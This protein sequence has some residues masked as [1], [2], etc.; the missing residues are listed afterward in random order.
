M[1]RKKLII[2]AI[3]LALVVAIGG[4]LAYFTDVQTKTNRF[5]MG[6][7]NILVDEPNWPGDPD[8]PNDEVPV[9]PNQ[10]TPK[11]PQITNQG[12]GEVYAFVKVT[13]PVASVKVGDATTATPTELFTFRHI[14]TP[15]QGTTPAVTA[16]GINSGWTLV[17]KTPTTL[18]ATTTSVTYVYAYGS[19]T[20]LTALQK[21]QTT[22]PIFDAVKFAD[23][24]ETE[25]TTTGVQ[26]KSY[27]VVVKGYGIQADGLGSNVPATVWPLVE[28]E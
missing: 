11:D 24:T 18:S 28:A 17:S 26:G 10:E 9:V 25:H 15:A 4:I 7:V 16:D 8:D 2:T 21:N 19:A 13:V 5:K 12:D 20:E 22:T 14:T 27:E 6:D 1:S 23:V 3:I